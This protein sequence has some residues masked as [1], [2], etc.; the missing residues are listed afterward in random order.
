[1]ST[2]S[3]IELPQ[4]L[5]RKQVAREQIGCAYDPGARLEQLPQLV[6]CLTRVSVRDIDRKVKH[7]QHLTFDEAFV[8]MC[9]VLAAT[10]ARFFDAYQ[11][12]LARA[13]A[14]EQLDKLQA[15]AIGTAFMQ[16]M[17]AKEAL[18]RLTPDEV[19]GMAAAALLDTVF[20]LELTDVVETCGMGGDRGL[21]GTRK[22]INASTLSAFVTTAVGL[23]TVKHG[24]Y[25]N[26]SAVGST[27]IIE[28]LG[29]RVDYTSIEQ[30]KRHLKLCNF[31]F[32][33]AH[34]VKT[35]HD[36]SHLLKMETINHVVGPM[37]PPFTSTTPITKLMGVNEKVHPATIAGAYAI[38][39]RRGIQ[40]NHCVVVV[41]GLD[42]ADSSFDPAHD[43]IGFA[44]HCVL[45]EVSPYSSVV[46]IARGSHLDGTWLIQ[47][48][49][50][51]VNEIDPESILIANDE[52]ALTEANRAALQGT[53]LALA[54][55][56]AMNA[57]L[58]VFAHRYNGEPPTNGLLRRCFDECRQAITSGAAWATL[59][60]YVEATN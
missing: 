16:L 5:R 57:A 41:G 19:A 38:L 32:L 58:A 51:G 40:Q 55:Y 34:L 2:L 43:L 10:N 44:Q 59:K 8:G 56:L 25:K 23:T 9:Y 24:S 7:G 33:D 50:F 6:H 37:S 60:C 52:Q 17:A 39:H 53:N 49:D 30:I 42:M 27:D 31:V 46:A 18:S 15:I 1:V 3:L 21:D 14:A 4:P 12:T 29:A 26:T 35:I 47:P 45:D 22:T 11:C 36:L 13:Y 20:Q 28:R 54:N 48:Q